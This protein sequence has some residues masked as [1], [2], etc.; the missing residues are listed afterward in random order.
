MEIILS[1]LAILATLS[2]TLYGGYHLIKAFLDKKS[3]EQFYQLRLNT[4]NESLPLKLQSYERM[5]L[6]LERIAPS[7]LIPRVNDDSYNVA[8]LQTVLVLTIR[9]EYSHNMSQQIYMSDDAW[10][11]IKIA[12]ED[13]IGLIN[14]SAQELNPESPSIELAKA[15]FQKVIDHQNDYVSN[16]ML[17]VKQEARSIM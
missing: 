16:A 2:I 17:F 4:V 1:I 5:V 7:N 8:Q 6:F 10:E 15:I 3:E 9:E 13:L 11:I 12:K 14:T